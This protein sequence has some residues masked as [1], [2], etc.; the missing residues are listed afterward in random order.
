ML[1]L[2]H[3]IDIAMD[4]YGIYNHSMLVLIEEDFIYLMCG[5]KED[6]HSFGINISSNGN[7]QYFIDGE[8]HR[9]TKFHLQMLDK[10][11]DSNE[12]ISDEVGC[13]EEAYKEFYSIYDEDE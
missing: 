2:H 13:D 5:D 9:C 10:Y 1:Y 6:K 7:T 4:E 11:Y 3:E 8:K 12:D